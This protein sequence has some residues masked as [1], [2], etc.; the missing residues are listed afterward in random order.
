MS[1]IK[2]LDSRQKLGCFVQLG[3]AVPT[4]RQEHSRARTG[5]SLGSAGMG[6]HENGIHTRHASRGDALIGRY[7]LQLKNKRAGLIFTDTIRSQSQ[8]ERFKVSTNHWGPVPRRAVL[9][10][11]GVWAVQAALLKSLVG[12]VAE[13]RQGG[14]SRCLFLLQYLL[15]NSAGAREGKGRTIETARDY[16]D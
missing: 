4:V 8:S 10:L 14:A 16:L 9:F 12:N 11:R 2:A 5:E 7:A 13:R 3:S 15:L 6:L 1:L